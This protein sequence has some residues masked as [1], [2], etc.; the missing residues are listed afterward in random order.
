M[1]IADDTLDT[2]IKSYEDNYKAFGEEFNQRE[3][4]VKQE[5][6]EKN[7]A[8]IKEQEKHKNLIQERN[9]TQNKTRR[10]E[11]AE[12]KYDLELRRKLN[13]DEYEQS[14]KNLLN[15]LEEFRQEQ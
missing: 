7:K 12:Y 8:W 2:L 6:L 10:R 9:E 14:Y 1:Q 5:I 4:S 11:A 3:E 15:Q 13:T